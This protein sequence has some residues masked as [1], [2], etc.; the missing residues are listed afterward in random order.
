MAV[1]ERKSEKGFL[2]SLAS[3]ARGF[4]RAE[5]IDCEPVGL[6]RP[7]PVGPTSAFEKG[8]W[9]GKATVR[10]DYPAHFIPA[11]IAGTFNCQ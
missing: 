4:P 9:R 1:E 10:A 8:P 3:S 5:I 6:T 7:N 11:V 2:S